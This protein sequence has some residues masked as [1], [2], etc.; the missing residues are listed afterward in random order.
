VSDATYPKY[1]LEVS[2]ACPDTYTSKITKSLL[3]CSYNKIIIKEEENNVVKIKFEAH[4]LKEM[5]EEFFTLIVT[6]YDG[7][8]VEITSSNFNHHFILQHCQQFLLQ[9]SEPAREQH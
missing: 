2:F 7:V 3:A 4:T 5:K 9:V 6:K 8:E 1:W